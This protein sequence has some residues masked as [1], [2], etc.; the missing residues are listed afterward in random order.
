MIYLIQGANVVILLV[1]LILPFVIAF[2]LVGWL[3]KRNE[4]NQT[5]EHRMKLMESRITDL[6]KYMQ[7]SEYYD[8]KLEE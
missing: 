6:E 7:E 2:F 1:M 5:I 8:S 4:Q 3:R